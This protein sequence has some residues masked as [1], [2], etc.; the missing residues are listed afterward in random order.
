[1][2]S[3][4]AGTVAEEANKNERK[5][6]RKPW[7]LQTA[8]TTCYLVFALDASTEDCSKPNDAFWQKSV[9]A[10][11]AL[12]PHSCRQYA[13]QTAVVRIAWYIFLPETLE[14]FAPS[15]HAHCATHITATHL[16]AGIDEFRTHASVSLMRTSPRVLC[17]AS[18]DDW[19]SRS[20]KSY[21]G[22][23]EEDRNGLGCE[24]LY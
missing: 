14:L 4:Q 2:G 22:K 16:P 6:P 7:E 15:L 18:N 23:D 11:S 5:G 17:P 24:L 8:V 3:R 20:L 19:R 1:M 21:F 10:Y 13:S 12:L 9:H